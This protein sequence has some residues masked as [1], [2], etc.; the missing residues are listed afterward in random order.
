VRNKTIHQKEEVE[1]KRVRTLSKRGGK[2][3]DPDGGLLV[4]RGGRKVGYEMGDGTP[5]E[6]GRAKELDSRAKHARGPQAYPGDTNVA[7]R[8]QGTVDL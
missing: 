2:G 8:R 1:G 7:E 4:N 3:S 6:H 5:W